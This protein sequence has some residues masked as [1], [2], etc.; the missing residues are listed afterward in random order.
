MG[1]KTAISWTE[2]T[3]NPWQ[4]CTKVSP[5]CA[6]CYMFRDKRKYGQ[7][8]EVVVRSKDP[9]FYA[10][11]KWKEP[12]LVFTCSWSDFFH[13]DADNWRE[14]AWEIIRKTPHLTYQI[15]TKRPER[16]LEHLPS[17]WGA[18][19]YPNVWLGTSVENQRWAKVRIPLLLQV[20]AVIRFLSCEP[21]LGPLDLVAAVGDVDSESDAWDEV[22]MLDDEHGPE[23]FITE[24]E[25]END[26][27]NFSDYH[28]VTN[29]EYTEHQAWRHQMA[30]FYSLHG[31]LHWVIVGGE[32]GPGFRPMDLDWA[33][34]I[35]RQCKELDIAFFY[36]QGASLRPGQDTMLDGQ[37]WHEFPDVS[38]VPHLVGV[39]A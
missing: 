17:D 11:L 25:A 26:W 13:A 28:L 21:L 6:H 29:P 16:I 7:N 24:A 3:W 38:H 34:D 10:P 30:Q 37:E 18:F 20:P 12:A 5:G 14:E 32:S 36:K 1:D 23:E 8:P 31:Q 2:K 9:T 19:G 4:G 15:L 22:N 35:R 33:R 39:P 27:I